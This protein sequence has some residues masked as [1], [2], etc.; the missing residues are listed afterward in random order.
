MEISALG[1]STSRS[2]VNLKKQD[3]GDACSEMSRQPRRRSTEVQDRHQ[4][5]YEVKESPNCENHSYLFHFRSNR[6]VLSVD[7]SFVVVK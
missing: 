7:P 6:S 5:N 2:M 1:G 3:S 4:E